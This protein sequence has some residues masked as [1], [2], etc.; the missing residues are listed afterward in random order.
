VHAWWLRVLSPVCIAARITASAWSSRNPGDEIR[1]LD[2][3]VYGKTDRFYVKQFEEETNLKCYLLVDQSASM[4]IAHEG[5]VSKFQYA[6]YL[7]AALSYLMMHQ[8]DAVGLALRAARTGKA[9]STKSRS[10]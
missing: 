2:W 9:L 8:R 3:K 10:K 4:G 5:R 7:A 1:H 6:S